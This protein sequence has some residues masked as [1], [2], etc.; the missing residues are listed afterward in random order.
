M[1]LEPFRVTIAY[2][3][4]E[5]G[6]EIFD[7]YFS[8]IQFYIDQ[9]AEGSNILSVVAGALD[10]WDETKWKK[11]LADMREICKDEG[12]KL[13]FTPLPESLLQ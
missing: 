10:G 2:D 1:K 11:G 3:E 5:L 8:D 13:V 12:R 7:A 9:V 4:G 6:I